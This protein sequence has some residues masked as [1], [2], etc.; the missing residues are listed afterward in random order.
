ML[1]RPKS[2]KRGDLPRIHWRS[3]P[4]VIREK[5]VDALDQ[6]LADP[7]GYLIGLDGNSHM[8]DEVDQHFRAHYRE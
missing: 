6:F 5:M 4:N 2:R 8:M 3:P 7:R 1:G